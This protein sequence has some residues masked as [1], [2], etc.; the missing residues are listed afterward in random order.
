MRSTP[1]TLRVLKFTVIHPSPQIRKI[2]R[3]MDAIAVDDFC[4]VETKH[5]GG[6]STFLVEARKKY[7]AIMA[8]ALYAA[9]Q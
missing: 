1:N 9:L 3:A 4:W 7:L 6:A 2:L 5:R 8:P